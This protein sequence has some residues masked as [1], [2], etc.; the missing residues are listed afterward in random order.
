MLFN[1]VLQLPIGPVIDYFDATEAFYPAIGLFNAAGTVVETNFHPEEDHIPA[2]A[3]LQRIEPVSNK[4][5]PETSQG[6][7]LDFELGSCD[8]GDFSEAYSCCNSL[9]M[10]RVFLVPSM[11]KM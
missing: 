6:T 5:I 11:E 8:G 10:T 3:I 1:T 4:D 7:L 9:T 2:S